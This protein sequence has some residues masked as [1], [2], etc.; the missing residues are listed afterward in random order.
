MVVMMILFFIGGLDVCVCTY[1]GG[2]CVCL[3]F[4]NRADKLVQFWERKEK[5]KKKKRIINH[6]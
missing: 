2:V 5:K 6:H 4:V 3:W 1:M